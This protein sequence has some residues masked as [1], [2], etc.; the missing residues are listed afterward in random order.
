MHR[1]TS[2]HREFFHSF[3]NLFTR[4][5]YD[6]RQDF[7]F[8][9][10][11]SFYLYIIMNTNTYTEGLVSV[12]I[13]TYNRRKVLEKSVR[14][15]ME[16]SYDNLEILIVDDRSTDNTRILVDE[17][18]KEDRRIRYILNDGDKGASGA[19]NKGI[20]K[21]VGEYIA[22]ED[23]DD[24]YV[25]DKIE[26]QLELLNSN[27]N[28][29]FCYSRFRKYIEDGRY[30]IVPGIGMTAESL[31]GNIIH[32]MMVDNVVGCPTLMVRHNIMDEI[33]G[34][35]THFRALEDY[36]LAIRLAKRSDAA[37]SDRELVYSPYTCEGV[38]T[39]PMNDL[40]ARLMLILKYKRLYIETGTLNHSMERVLTDAQDIGVL[41][42]IVPILEKIIS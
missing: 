26:Q 35:D 18:S 11:E 40:S 30:Y 31:A 12:I 9:Y 42:Q 29:G 8:Y 32:Q 23:S 36:D 38:S 1:Q 15:V 27:K 5:I 16:Q 14:S 21:A 7:R 13:P 17:L 19:R 6:R 25:P 28:C 3:S 41:D 10:L 20:F 24:Y 34:F 37:F 39:N 4:F 33:G 2:L 22:F